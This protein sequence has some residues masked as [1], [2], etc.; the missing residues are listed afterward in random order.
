M[1]LAP[2]LICT[3]TRLYHLQAVVESLLLSPLACNT[4]LYI[5]SDA[6]RGAVEVTIVEKV[7]EY[8]DNISGFKKVVHIKREKNLGHFSNF[9]EST[10]EVFREHEK[11]IK[12]E[13]DV[14]VGKFF[15]EYMN[16]YLT[17]FA[18]NKDVVSISSNIWPGLFFDLR[19]PK[20]L[21]LTNGWG[22]ATWRDKFSQID[23]SNALACKFIN[24]TNLF[25]KMNFFNPSLLG[26]VNA[27]AKSRLI[28]GDVNWALHLIKNEKYVLFPP[29]PLSGNIGFDGTGQNCPA[30]KDNLHSIYFDESFEL[31]EAVDFA[32]KNDREVIFK[33]FGGYK[34]LGKQLILF[35][36]ENLFGYKF[37]LC[38]VALKAKIRE[39]LSLKYI[40]F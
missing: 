27:V 1:I 36:C 20:L 3:H 18:K 32:T 12:L 22:W 9:Q 21:P 40:L 7:R 8:V 23:H 19:T 11:I 17:V 24:N 35:Y 6:A 30:T 10:I 26:M 37:I 5:S 29:F 33:Y 39:S 2:V 14:V 34:K 13:D 16:Y 28:A 31:V 25:W 4:I 15:L 38:I